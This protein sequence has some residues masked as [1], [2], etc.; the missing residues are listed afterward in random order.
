M[1]SVQGIFVIVWNL[2]DQNLIVTHVS[3][4]LSWQ[5][6]VYVVLLRDE[7]YLFQTCCTCINWCFLLV[8][9]NSSIINTFAI[10]L[11]GMHVEEALEHVQETVQDFKTHMDKWPSKLFCCDPMYHPVISLVLNPVVTNS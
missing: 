9:R 7:K 8:F 6:S 1:M 4:L 10:D 3:F 5:Y 11:H 2:I